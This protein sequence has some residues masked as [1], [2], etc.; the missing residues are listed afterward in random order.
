MRGGRRDRTDPV[1]LLLLRARGL[2]ALSSSPTSPL[3][4]LNRGSLDP[5]GDL[6][7]LGGI[8]FGG[9]APLSATYFQGVPYLKPA[10]RWTVPSD[11]NSASNTIEVIGG[12]GGGRRK[13]HPGGR[14]VAVA[15]LE[16]GECLAHIRLAT[17]F[18]RGR[19]R[20][21]WRP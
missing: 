9:T 10:P 8:R 2:K 1:R 14:P 19:H 20:Q 11:W 7:L 3:L 13:H 21:Y 16:G 12:G 15:L 18:V 4:I 6:R 5:I 17:A